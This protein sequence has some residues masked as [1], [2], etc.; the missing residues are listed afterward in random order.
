MSA[1]DRRTVLRGA[2]C[3]C[4][5]GLLAAC[6]GG[7]GSTAADAPAPPAPVPAGSGGGGGSKPLVELSEV[8]VGGAVA[9]EASDG[10]TVLVTQPAEGEVMAFS[11]VCPHEGCS[12]SPDD[13]Q[14]SCPCHGSQFSLAGKVKRGPAQRSLT[15]VPVTVKDGQV[16]QA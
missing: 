10:S 14:L 4:G 5:V 9:V 16:L 2:A 15:P 8:P 1:P 11:S 13:D 6:G 7:T 12:V 3:A